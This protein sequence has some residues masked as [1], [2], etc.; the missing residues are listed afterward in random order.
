[1]KTPYYVI[2]KKELDNGYQMLV[3]SLKKYWGNYMIGYSYKTNALPWVLK[4]FDRKGCYAEVVSEDEY[5]LAQLIGV[6]KKKIIY[7][8][9]IKTKATFMEALQNGNIVNIDSEREI[10]WLDYLQ[11]TEYNLGIRVNFDIEKFCPSQSQCG[12]EGGALW[13]LL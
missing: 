11:S 7:N 9:P 12:T 10:E 5:K 2:H 1:M 3:N 6:D 13:I 8:G 4:E